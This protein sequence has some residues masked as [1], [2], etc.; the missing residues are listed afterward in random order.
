MKGYEVVK[1]ETLDLQTSDNLVVKRDGEKV[2]LVTISQLI[3]LLGLGGGFKPLVVDVL[4]EIGESGF[5]YLVRRED[6]E[7]GDWCDEYIWLEEET[8][9]EHIGSNRVDLSDYY[10]KEEIDNLEEWVGTKAEYEAL[11]TPLPEGKKVIITDDQQ[12]GGGG[13]VDYEPS[14]WTCDDFNIQY[15]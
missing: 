4:P 11:T 8:A 9:Y 7:I 6:S 15:N 2:C 12:G 10:T 5:L 1:N 13:S 14:E 3:E